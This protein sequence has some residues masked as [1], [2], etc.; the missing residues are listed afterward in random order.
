M[1][2]HT[3]LRH[4]GVWL[5]TTSLCLTAGL[6]AYA[7]PAPPGDEQAGAPQAGD[8]NTDPPALAGRVAA[9]TGSVSFHAGGET[10]W[11]AATPN[12]PVTNG[13]AYWTEPQ[14]QATLEVA[15]DRL[16]LAPSTELDVSQLDQAQFTTT[17]AQGA[18][19]L[20]LNTLP[21]GQ[22]VT[23]N[24]P[25]GAVQITQPGRYEIVAGDTNDATA[26]TVVDGAA[27]VAGTNLSLDVGP[28]QT[29]SIGG[30]DTL[31][32]S[33]GPIQTDDFLQGLLRA[34]ARR[35]Y[36]AGVPPQVQ[37]MT[38]AADLQTYGAFTQTA[39]YGAV[40]YPQSVPANWAPY[41]DG[42][43]AYVN[44]WGWTWVDNARWGFAPFHYGRWVQVQNRWGWI[45]GGGEVSVSVG[46]PYPVY[47]PALVTFLNV[48]G[49]AFAGA[50][51][52]F[53]AGAYAPAWIPLGPR[54]PYYPWY[55]CQPGYFARLNTPYGVPRT[56]ID[57][58]PTYNTFIRNTTVNNVTRNVFINER[59]A[60]AVPAAAFASGRPIGAI[61]RPVPQAALVG[62]RPFVG[63]LALAPTAQTPNL[64]RE[65]ARRFDIAA[66]A[67][68]ARVTAG[69]RIEQ[70]VDRP[71][72]RPLL[73]RAAL[74]PSVHT[75]PAA[76]VHTGAPVPAS[77]GIPRGPEA[78]PGQPALAPGADRHGPEPRGKLPDAVA[79]RTPAGLPPLRTP[80]SARPDVR[81]GA[82]PDVPPAAR[83][84]PRPANEATNRAARQPDAVR[85]ATR[86]AAEPPPASREARPA[87]QIRKEPPTAAAAA[88]RPA[89]P[90]DTLQPARRPAAE[91]RPVATPAPRQAEP[92]RPAEPVRP[93][94]ASPPRAARPNAAAPRPEPRQP[95]EPRRAE[96]A[97]PAPAAEPRA[98]RPD[99]VEPRRV[100]PVQVE[101]RQPAPAPHREPPHATPDK[102]P[103][104]GQ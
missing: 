67:A 33:V 55:H 94:A 35:A 99:A 13:D 22:N 46:A 74:P 63:R 31:Q 26:V 6:P 4:L 9:L 62:A 54:E 65:T 71:H 81:P 19:F 42:R 39:Q 21:Q 57:R 14:A 87:P 92:R 76:Q 43:W 53:A 28:Q 3:R 45:P 60:T 38:G 86:P 40:W 84:E 23:I 77:I 29:A 66:P 91:P 51:V 82:R 2:S 104:P 18:V 30:T 90:R 68:P 96:P 98:P 93:E 78:R 7:Q 32:G 59:G 8:A 95:A 36:A 85:P 103:P 100:T 15:D 75:V 49:A 41:R 83:P 52:G 61:Y 102:K 72:G 34:P 12:Y 10:Q 24:T 89:E 80:G 37:Y 88:P 1:R 20:Q 16:V 64:P 69:P 47:S 101:P 50:G 17:A 5:A 44:P 70:A 48:G 79:P 58:G 97:R 25:R 11:S 73:R 56:I 27:H